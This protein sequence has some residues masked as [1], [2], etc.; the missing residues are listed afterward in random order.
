MLYVC[1]YFENLKCHIVITVSLPVRNTKLTLLVYSSV[2]RS[3]K[4][5]LVNEHC[6]MYFIY[7]SLCHLNI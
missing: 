5:H 6:F 3:L 4:Y 2:L 7:K 1:L